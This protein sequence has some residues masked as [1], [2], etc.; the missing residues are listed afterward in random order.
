MVSEQGIHIPLISAGSRPE[1]AP[2]LTSVRIVRLRLP[3]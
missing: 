1:F 2:G 3:I